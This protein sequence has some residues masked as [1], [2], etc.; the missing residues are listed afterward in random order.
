MRTSIKHLHGP[1]PTPD[2][3]ET[4]IRHARELRSEALRDYLAAARSGLGRSGRHLGSAVAL[5][6]AL[7]S[8]RGVAPSQ[9]RR[10]P[11][12][13]ILPGSP[14]WLQALWSRMP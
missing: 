1:A 12:W 11:F 2:E 10:Q 4:A 14:R 7:E 13:S 5:H 9:F 8:R 3:L 6:P